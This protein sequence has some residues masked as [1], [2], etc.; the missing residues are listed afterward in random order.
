M[1]KPRFDDPVLQLLTWD[2]WSDAFGWLH[3]ETWPDCGGRGQDL[4]DA[5]GGDRSVM[6]REIESLVD[7]LYAEGRPAAG[8]TGL[9]WLMLTCDPRSP[10]SFHRVLPQLQHILD[11]TL[12]AVDEDEFLRR[13]LRIWW[14]ACEGE[15]CGR[16]A[17]SIWAIAASETKHDTEV[18]LD[19]ILEGVARRPLRLDADGPTLVVMPKDKARK[20]KADH[21]IYKEMVG[22]RI[23]LVVAKD[24]AGIRAQLHREYL[25]AVTAV[26][27][28]MRDL[29]EGQPVRMKPA[30]L[31]GSPGCGK[32]RLIRRL[33]DLLGVGTYRFDGGSSQDGVGYGGTPRRWSDSTPCVPARA[34]QMFGQAN[35]I[36]MVDEIDKAAASHSNGAMWNVLL[37][38]LDRETAARVR[39]VSLD[40]ELDLSWVCHLA[41]SLHND[42]RPLFNPSAKPTAK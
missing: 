19:A 24:V 14:R 26:D 41:A 5:L 27:I 33:G 37:G 40:S 1:K 7:E 8:R 30:I 4:L 35:P 21:S 20:L 10:S 29:R 32:S 16:N 17:P 12:I 9:A 22:E 2:K 3:H 39:D 23:P 36:V 34:V 28:L 13:R 42:V 15:W 31:V 18:Q 25:H 38:H 6:R 11:E